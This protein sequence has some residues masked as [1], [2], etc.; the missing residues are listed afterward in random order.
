MKQVKHI[1]LESAHRGIVMVFTTDEGAV[2]LQIT[3]FEARQLALRLMRMLGTKR[4][5]GEGE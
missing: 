5:E 4:G 2:T 1:D 3:K